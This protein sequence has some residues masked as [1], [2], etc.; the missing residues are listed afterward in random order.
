MY[1]EYP[2]ISCFLRFGL[3]KLRYKAYKTF[4]FDPNF[5][6]DMRSQN[7]KLW[8]KLS[9]MRKNLKDEE[10]ECLLVAYFMLFFTYS[11]WRQDFSKDY[12][13]SYVENR[14]CLP[15]ME[16]STKL[17]WRWSA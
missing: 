11:Y 14:S 2:F 15:L 13:L 9:D 17:A 5:G 8:T 16:T 3:Y 1:L 12:G 10:R 4:G 6:F 7:K